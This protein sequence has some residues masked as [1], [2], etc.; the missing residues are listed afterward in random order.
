MCFGAECICRPGHNEGAPVFPSHKRY[1]DAGM[2]GMELLRRVKSADP[3]TSFIIITGL[4]DLNTAVDSLR[5][6]LVIS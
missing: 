6:A 5:L 3:E 4:M 1:D 2:S